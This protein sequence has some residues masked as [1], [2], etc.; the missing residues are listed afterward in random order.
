MWDSHV[1]DGVRDHPKILNIAS[2][3]ATLQSCKSKA[4]VPVLMT[5]G[6]RVIKDK[7]LYFVY[8]YLN[9][10]YIGQAHIGSDNTFTDIKESVLLEGGAGLVV[11]G[12][13]RVT[14]TGVV[15]IVVEDVNKRELLFQQDKSGNFKKE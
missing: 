4:P 2:H 12:V 1:P 11:S 6:M 5:C 14:D 15:V 7:T 3:P 8:G 9:N 10:L 13:I